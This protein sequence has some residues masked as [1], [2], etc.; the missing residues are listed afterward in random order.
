M[1]EFNDLL[2]LGAAAAMVFGYD[3]LKK[4]AYNVLFYSD[5]TGS[6]DKAQKYNSAGSIPNLDPNFHGSG[7]WAYAQ[8]HLPLPP[9][10]VT[11]P[12]IGLNNMRPAATSILET[13]F[14]QSSMGAVH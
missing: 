3:T 10:P 4:N 12:L 11:E 1:S 7:R 13:N 14:A 8:T 5:N 6:L 2:I 9:A